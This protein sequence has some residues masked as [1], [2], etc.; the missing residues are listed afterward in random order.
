[1]YCPKCGATVLKGDVTCKKCGAVLNEA[2]TQYKAENVRR[3]RAMLLFKAWIGATSG[4]HLKW[5]GYDDKAA[6]IAKRYGLKEQIST[7]FHGAF[8]PWCFLKFIEI[9][10]YQTFVCMGIMVGMYRTDAAGH[11]VRWITKVKKK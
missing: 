6:E 7:A 9:V 10:G 8:N 4:L 11:P 2:S 3:S 5:L 1:M